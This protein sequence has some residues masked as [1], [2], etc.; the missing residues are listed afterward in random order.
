MN[1]AIRII[2]IFWAIANL[3]LGTS[4]LYWAFEQTYILF[5]TSDPPLKDFYLPLSS[6]WIC[7][8]I[9]VYLGIIMLKKSFR[10]RRRSKFS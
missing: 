7:G 4:C 3:I 9:Y 8:I 2:T 10:R 1:N 5:Q 6:V